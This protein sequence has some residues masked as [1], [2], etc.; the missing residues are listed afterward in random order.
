LLLESDR[1][2]VCPS[3]SGS[4]SP[5]RSSTTTA[6]A[7]LIEEAIR[8]RDVDVFLAGIA[9]RNFT[10]RYW[11]RI[12]PL[13]RPKLVI[14]MHYDD[15]FAPVEDPMRFLPQMYVAAIPEELRAVDRDVAVA[16]LPRLAPIRG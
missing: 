5:E 16:A 12:L 4:P 7:D 14:P 15:F 8:D 10:P 11:Q 1:K 3:A 9:G 13:V 2:L 6:A